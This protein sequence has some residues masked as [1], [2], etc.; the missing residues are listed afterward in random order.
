M[1]KRSGPIWTAVDVANS[2][3]LGAAR[4]LDELSVRDEDAARL[5]LRT[6]R[7]YRSLTP[8]QYE[9]A[10]DW[11]K[12]ANLYP[13]DPSEAALRSSGA[14][15]L[16][17]AIAAN[18]PPW[19]PDADSL[20]GNPDELPI[21]VAELGER[22]GLTGPEVLDEIRRTWR[23]FDDTAQRNLGAAGEIALSVW[24]DENVSARVIQV[25][26]FDDTAGF[27]IALTDDRGVRARIEVK[28]TRRQDSVVVFL[29]RNEVETMRTHIDWC[30]QVVHLD[31][32]NQLSQ[33]SWVASE[34]ILDAEPSDGHHAT[35]QSMKMTL[36]VHL[37]RPGVAP[38]IE[39]LLIRR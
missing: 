25:S 37:L 26:L 29:S 5:S 17:A 28:A 2:I 18:A 3:L 10:L 32:A 33:L 19:L 31:P 27:D 11:L 38:P 24:L 30:L 23:K 34:T 13:I 4:W 20:I 12:L 22:L 36:P 6:Q 8:T 14:R 16:G 21:D 35:W 39:A 7:H 15:V 9:T 1:H